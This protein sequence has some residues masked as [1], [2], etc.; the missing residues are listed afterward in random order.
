LTVDVGGE[1]AEGFEVLDG[2]VGEGDGGEGLFDFE[3][4]FHEVE[5]VEAEVVGEG[6][7]EGDEGRVEMEVGGD[8]GLEFEFGEG[9]GLNR[10]KELNR[11]DAKN[12][13][14]TKRY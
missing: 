9:H 10:D 5:G 13:K 11:E 7:V 8:E 12:A 3:D 1:L 2:F 14:K 4:D 6:L